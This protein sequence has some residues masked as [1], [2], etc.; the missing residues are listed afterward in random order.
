MKHD[1]AKKVVYNEN[2]CVNYGWEKISFK[3][4]YEHDYVDW[5]LKHIKVGSTITFSEIWAWK[6]E[7]H[8][9][10]IFLMWLIFCDD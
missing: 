2:D 10:L 5:E 3:W 7:I 6:I 9:N 8:L 4:E 1:I